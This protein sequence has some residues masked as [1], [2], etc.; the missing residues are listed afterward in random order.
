MRLL[1]WAYKWLDSST[2]I[3]DA[4]GVSQLLA[5]QRG[6]LSLDHSCKSIRV[7]KSAHDELHTG[8][9]NN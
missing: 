9:S 1:L 5:R 4:E 8:A 7:L 3:L 6:M 2:K